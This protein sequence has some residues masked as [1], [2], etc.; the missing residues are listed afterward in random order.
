M[1]VESTSTVP[2]EVAIA[3]LTLCS[4]DNLQMTKNIERKTLYFHFVSENTANYLDTTQTMIVPKYCSERSDKFQFKTTYNC[5]R[6]QDNSLD[7][8]NVCFILFGQVHFVLFHSN[9]PYV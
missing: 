8:D 1:L 4:T 9:C 3:L 7:H 2:W 5:T 6:N